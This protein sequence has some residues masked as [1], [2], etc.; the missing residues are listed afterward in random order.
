MSSP[1][2]ANNEEVETGDQLAVRGAM[3]M[4]C[5]LQES[6]T[7]AKTNRYGFM[8]NAYCR[9]EIPYAMPPDAC[10]P[11]TVSTQI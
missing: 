4:V 11:G 3:K 7:I 1:Y 2:K 9:D 6:M 5:L 10:T 8:V